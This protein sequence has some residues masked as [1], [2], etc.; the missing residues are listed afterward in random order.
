MP[1]NVTS[2][3]EG[4]EHM[5]EMA[6]KD[7]DLHNY[8]L[9]RELSRHSN[10]LDQFQRQEHQ[11]WAAPDETAFW[12]RSSYTILALFSVVS[13]VG[14]K[15]ERF[16]RARSSLLVSSQVVY[17][18]T[19]KKLFQERYCLIDLLPLHANDLPLIWVKFDLIWNRRRNP[20]RQL[21]S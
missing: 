14:E 20:L 9:W 19:W 2:D 12:S 16:G 3:W 1:Q 10:T 15:N 21:K 18:A 5:L 8:G 7:S 13:C 4:R 6:W 17:P 11:A